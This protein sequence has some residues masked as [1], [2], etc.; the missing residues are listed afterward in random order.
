MG[1]AVAS[2]GDFDLPEFFWIIPQRAETTMGLKA[3]RTIL[4]KYDGRIMANGELWEIWSKS[5]GAG[6]YRVSLKPW[7]G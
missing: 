7:N 6:V 4:L 2:G 5:I 1:N 3:L